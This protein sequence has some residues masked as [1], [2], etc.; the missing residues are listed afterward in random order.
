MYDNFAL[1]QKLH[2]MDYNLNF[3]SILF[4]HIPTLIYVTV[5]QAIPKF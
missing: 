4:V 3:S 1:S 5:V 2:L